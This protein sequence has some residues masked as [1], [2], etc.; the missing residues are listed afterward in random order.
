MQEESIVVQ[1]PPRGPAA[2]L[3]PRLEATRADMRALLRTRSLLT[4]ALTVLVLAGLLAA[5]DWQ[6]V[7]GVSGRAGGLLVI[8]IAACALLGFGWLAAGRKFGRREAAVELEAAFLDLGQ[9]VRTTLDYAEPDA[10]PIPAAP[11]LVQALADDT[12][13]RTH[14]L[15]FGRLVPWHSLRRITAGLAALVALFVVLLVVSPEARIAAQR[16]FLI[17][18]TY[19][20]LDVQPGDQTL[21]VGSDLAVQA[22]VAGRPVSELTLQHRPAGS[23]EGWTTIPFVA[24][25][26]ES[27]RPDKLSGAFETALKDC[28]NDLEY[29]VVAGPVE[30]PVYRLTITRPLV[31][32]GIEAH[33]EPPAYTRRP[34]AVVK[35]G[36]FKVIAGS[37]VR[38]RITLDR[39]PQ[40]ARLVMFPAGTPP[41]ALEVNGNELTG[42]LPS[43]DKDVEYEIAAEAADGMRLEPASRYRIAV[44]P[45]RKPTVRFLKPREQIEVTP[46]TEVH[47]K[48]EA[49]DDF[50]LSAVGIVYQVGNGPQQT[51]FLQPDPAQPTALKAEAVLA[52][53]EHDL[54]HQDAITYYA[55]AEDN[56]PN[57]PQRTTTELQF[58]D[59][60]PFKRSYQLLETGGS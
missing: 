47:M 19:T 44:Q 34:A 15:D 10:D 39:E 1:R 4:A 37:R 40:S 23:R 26:A 53:E 11:Q 17:P 21:K 14:L 20:Q 28:Q 38:F 58:I 50:G 48:I 7:L 42:E 16:L 5:A 27:S 51:L 3:V 24:P 45:D 35:E 55:F 18:A 46:T 31:L 30:S 22:T 57:P 6:W 41:V 59:I 2:G 9:R 36:N 33:V 13:G 25:D 49:G 54:S 8:T 12:E 32:K 52:L 43:V 29:R 56:H 60:R